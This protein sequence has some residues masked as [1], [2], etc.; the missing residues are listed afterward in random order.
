M[1]PT[2]PAV[3][4]ARGGAGG[5]G[6]GGGGAGSAGQERQRQQHHLPLEAGEGSVPPVETGAQRVQ[7]CL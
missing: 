7:T 1:L 6:A 4:T 2:V 3:G 5:G